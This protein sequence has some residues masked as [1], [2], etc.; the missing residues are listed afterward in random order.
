MISQNSVA[1]VLE[2]ANVEDVIEEFVPL[3]KRGVNMLGLCPFHNE[4]TPSFTVSPT[5]NLYKCFGC[6]KGGNAVSFIMEHENY[7]FPE[8]IRYL[9]KKYGIELEE[10]QQT[11]QEKEKAQEQESLYIINEFAKDFFHTQ[12]LNTDEGK[13]VGFNYFK[14]RGLL[15]KTI[16]EFNLGYSP[17]NPKALLNEAKEKGFNEEYLG[18]LGLKSKSNLDFFRSESFSQ[19]LIYRVK[20]LPLVGGHCQT[21]KKYLST[22]TLLSQIFIRRVNP[23]TES[24]KLKIKSDE[25]ITVIWSKGILMYLICIK[26]MSKM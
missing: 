6:G 4:K 7:S 5:K 2:M 20:S 13:S 12:L 22:S 26:M 23:S 10:T 21:I 24:F 14:N 25:M 11:D 18:Q 17:T 8:A 1:Q 9:A 3:K 16:T 19:S 15:L